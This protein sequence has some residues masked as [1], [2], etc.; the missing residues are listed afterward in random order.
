VLVQQALPRPLCLLLLVL[1]CICVRPHR[2][3]ADTTLPAC[4]VLPACHVMRWVYTQLHMRT[5][6]GV[7]DRWVLQVH[8]T[9]AQR[10]TLVSCGQTWHQL[11]SCGQTCLQ[12][13]MGVCMYISWLEV[14]DVSA[15][16]GWHGWQGFKTQ[17][18]HVSHLGV[19]HQQRKVCG[20]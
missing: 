11:V 5:F 10:S 16:C 6:C 7:A 20:C 14:C 18:R 13:Y 15:A 4:L 8:C 3:F 19:C 2:S 17:E 12:Q 9:C 1:E